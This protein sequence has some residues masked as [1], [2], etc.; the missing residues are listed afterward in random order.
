MK[1]KFA[2]L[3]T[4]HAAAVWSVLIGAALATEPARVNEKAA[5]T[6]A[7]PALDEELRAVV[8]D[9][10]YPLASLSAL[11]VRDGKVVYQQQ[12]G[13]RFIDVANAANNK[14]ANAETMYR[15]ASISKL[16]TSL[17]VMKMVEAGKL[18]LDADVGD[19]LGY[20]FRNP[21]FPNDKITLRML[22]SHTSSLRD[23]AG[24]NFG[25][26]IRLKDILV[27]G[28]KLVENRGGSQPN[29]AGSGPTNGSSNDI[30]QGQKTWSKNGRPGALFAYANLP[31]G[32]IG[33]LM[34]RVS[35]VRFDRL[36][37]QL[38]LHPMS[39]R[40]GF[41]PAD[42]PCADV[43]NIATLYRKRSETN[44][45]EVWDPSGP[46]IPQV[47]DYTTTAAVSR[48]TP[49]YEIGSNGTLFGPQ[50]SIRL[51]AADLGKLMLMLMND[52][53]YSGKQ[54][55]QKKTIDTMFAEQ[56]RDNGKTGGK[57]QEDN[58]EGGNNLFN[59]WGLGNQH[60]IDKS[61]VGK[62]DRIVEAGGVTGVGHLGDAWGLTSAFI[63]NRKTKNGVIFLSGG[64]GFN[65]ETAKGKYSAMYRYEERIL[66]ALYRRAIMG[67]AK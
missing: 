66:D 20:K 51:S 10:T 2:A 7:T 14:P 65:P 26:K 3:M 27:P 11:A 17:G 16:V 62:G 55:L 40:G 47:D 57:N 30:P 23:D 59:A 37:Q 6:S 53:K 58:D 12:F 5:M 33:T 44:G 15:I 19:Y 13:N 24:Y 52:G 9:A 22:M 35:G 36:M 60:F 50:G 38:I 39:L 49:D 18:K 63:F 28:G 54:I 64:P 41:H 45:K 29:G 8:N 48:A 61:G 4:L 42:M 32:V 21:H 1:I 34:E 67:E 25:E 31:W 56:W 46:W 43:Q